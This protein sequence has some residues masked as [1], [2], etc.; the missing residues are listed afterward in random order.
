MTALATSPNSTAAAADSAV[1]DLAPRPLASLIFKLMDGLSGATLGLLFYGGWG[2][3]ANSA[4]GWS[5]ALRSGAAQGAM[6]F[7]VT[8]SGVTLM[9]RL[10]GIAGPLWWRGAV[11]ILGSLLLIYGGIVGVHLWLGTPEI[12]LTLA[13]GL[14]ITIVFCCVFVGSMLRIESA[15]RRQA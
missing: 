1:A 3:W 8:L 9:K 11:S 5:V 13:P 15:A 10:F 2:V 4:Y 7:V 12:L 14:P 6:S